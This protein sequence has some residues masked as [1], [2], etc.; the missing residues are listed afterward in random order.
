MYDSGLSLQQIM[1]GYSLLCLALIL[2][3]TVFLIPPLQ[4]L[5]HW[6]E[7]ETEI[8]QNFNRRFSILAGPDFAVSSLQSYHDY[9]NISITR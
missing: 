2:L 3:G 4:V 7:E 6:I 9:L 1:I 8:D 5:L